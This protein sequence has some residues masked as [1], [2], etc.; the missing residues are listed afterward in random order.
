ML[1]KDVA[2]SCLAP[3]A[4]AL[5]RLVKG[6]N[7]VFPLRNFHVFRLPQSE[8][9]NGSRRPM[10]ARIAMTIAHADRRTGHGELDRPTETTS[11]VAFWTGHM[12]S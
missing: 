8:G 10:A 1:R 12:D 9:I 11:I 7:I 6:P 3:L 4:I 5:R 2:A